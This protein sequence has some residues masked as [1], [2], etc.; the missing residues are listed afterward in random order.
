M[1]LRFLAPL[2][3]AALAAS[4]AVPAGAEPGS[5]LEPPAPKSLPKAARGDRTQNLEFLFGALKVAP[6]ETS[7]KAIE[8]RIWALWMVSPSDTA[9]LLMTRV[10]TAIE[11]KDTDLALKLLD[12]IVKIK[13]DYL[14][15]WNRRATLY[16]MKKDYGHSLADIREV[17]RR[18][19]RHFGALMGFGMI[20]QDIGDDKR[21]LEVYR[22]VLG[23]YPKMQRVPDLV[24]TLQEKV[25]GRDI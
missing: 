15:A 12:G 8:Q 25:E 11:A 10:R 17:L 20:M 1:R 9:T 18:E 2:F 3:A 16:Y 4:L 7:A 13:P 5:W 6:D 23:V 21:A 24:K 14:E 19:P 22:R